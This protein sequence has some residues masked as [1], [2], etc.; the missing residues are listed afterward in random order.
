MSMREVGGE[1]S[2]RSQQL[3]LG[4]R[5]SQEDAFRLL[6]VLEFYGINEGSRSERLREFLRLMTQGFQIEI[7]SV[8]FEEDAWTNMEAQVLAAEKE[9]LNRTTD[10]LLTNTVKAWERATGKAP[11]EIPEKE[12][13]LN[14]RMDHIKKNVGEVSENLQTVMANFRDIALAYKDSEG[15]DR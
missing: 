6:R 2:L 4:V 12:E 1:M 7:S 10:V 5:L 15:Y 8:R 3:W 14:V 9:S 13:P 11:Q